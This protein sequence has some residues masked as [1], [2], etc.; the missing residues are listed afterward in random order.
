[1]NKKYKVGIVGATGAVGQELIS[2]LHDRNFPMESLALLASSRSAGKTISYKDKTFVVEE[3]KPE[4]F[5]KLDIAIFSAGASV[6][7]ILVPEAAKRGCIAIDNSSAFRMDPEVPLIVPEVNPHALA[8]HKNII[9]NP[10]CSTIQA[11]V[12]LAPLHKLFGIERIIFTTLQS[13]CALAPGYSMSLMV[14]PI[15]PSTHLMLG[16]AGV[17]LK[18]HFRYSGWR[19]FLLA[20]AFLAITILLGNVPL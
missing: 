18:T 17:D 5:D 4:S 6:S 7:K 14:C 20:L 16:V 2:L 3:A 8:G 11:A 13:V 19:L 9:A 15:M 10:N 12:V 1:M